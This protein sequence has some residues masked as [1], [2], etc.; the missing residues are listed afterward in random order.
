MGEK[1]NMEKEKKQVRHVWRYVFIGLA[2]GAANVGTLWLSMVYTLRN[3]LFGPSPWYDWPVVLVLIFGP[4]VGWLVW[5][6]RHAVRLGGPVGRRIFDAVMYVSAMGAGFA[7][8][9]LALMAA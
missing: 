1:K 9:W 5:N 2:L 8:C 6:V 7:I 3:G 4:C